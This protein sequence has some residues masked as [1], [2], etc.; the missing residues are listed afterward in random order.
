ME[1]LRKF[2]KA[3]KLNPLDFKKMK[4]KLGGGDP[5]VSVCRF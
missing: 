1:A 5:L 3:E 2:G 4:R